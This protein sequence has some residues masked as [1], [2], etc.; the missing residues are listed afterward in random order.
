MNPNESAFVRSS[1]PLRAEG[2][3]T[4]FRIRIS[5]VPNPSE[6]TGCA[7]VCHTGGGHGAADGVA[8]GAGVGASPPVLF[9]LF[10][11]VLFRAGSAA[12]PISHPSYTAAGLG[13]ACKGESESRAWTKCTVS[14]SSLM[15]YM[16]S[17]IEANSGAVK[18]G[19]GIARLLGRMT[20]HRMNLPLAT[21]L[22][23]L[24]LRRVLRAG[25]V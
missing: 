24:T 13:P 1:L 15:F 9:A 19:S 8:A 16:V 11:F 5:I 22:S 10:C 14:Y 25:R 7:C 2:R 21:N 18:V 6:L 3:W 12:R 23:R 20:G 4:R 17:H